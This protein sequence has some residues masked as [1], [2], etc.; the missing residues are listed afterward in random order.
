MMKNPVKW[1]CKHLGL[2][3]NGCVGFFELV[4]WAGSMYSFV[5]LVIIYVGV[6]SMNRM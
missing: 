3:V 5:G 6:G 2:Q 4:F 1:L